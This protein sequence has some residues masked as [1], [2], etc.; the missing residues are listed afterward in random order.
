MNKTLF[1]SRLFF[2]VAIL[3]SC[4]DEILATD[5]KR[6]HSNLDLLMIQLFFTTF[7]IQ[8]K[9]MDISALI[10]KKKLNVKHVLFK[11]KIFHGANAKRNIFK[12]FRWKIAYFIEGFLK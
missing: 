3:N 12:F 7:E 10:V 4:V 8:K 2:K 5:S 1:L 6:A 9:I 11:K